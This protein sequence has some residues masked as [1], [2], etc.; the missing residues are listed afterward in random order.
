[1]CTYKFERLCFYVA[2]LKNIVTIINLPLFKNESKIGYV[3]SHFV[4]GCPKY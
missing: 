3:K 2:A 4:S 1:M